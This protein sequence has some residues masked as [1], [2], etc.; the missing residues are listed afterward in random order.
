[1]SGRAHV[2]A[3]LLRERGVRCLELAFAGFNVAEHGTWVA[4]LVYAYE[5][6]VD[7]HA[8]APALV[9]PGAG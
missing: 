1:V 8:F 2:I 4:V 6:R 3:G 5:Q 9:Q 7:A